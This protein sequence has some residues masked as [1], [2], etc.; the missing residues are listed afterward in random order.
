MTA[1]TAQPLMPAPHFVHRWLPPETHRGLLR[2]GLIVGAVALGIAVMNW[3][4]KPSFGSLVQALVYSYAISM[5]I[6]FISDPLRIA[7]RRFLQLGAPNYWTLNLRSGAWMLLGALF[8]YALGTWIGDAYA[9]VSTFALLS[10]S[11]KRFWGFLISS[12]AISLGFLFF[13]YQRERA[14]SLQKQAAEARLRLLETQLEPHMLFNTLANLRAL[15]VIDQDK[16]VDMLDRLNGYLRA[17]LRA[18]R[19]ADAEQRPHTLQ[20]EFDRL[21]DYLELMAVRM[22]PRLRYTLT[23]PPA[24]ARHPLPP[25]LLQPLVENA[26]RHG[27][28]PHL[29]GGEIVV[30]AQA[31]GSSLLLRVNDTGAGCAGA[32]LADRPGG[33]FGLSQ[34]RERLETAFGPAPK[35]IERLQW[36]SAPNQG[37]Q[38]LLRLPLDTAA[39]ESTAP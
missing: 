20:D 8:G 3:L 2:R 14:L 38:I 11:P 7:A 27:L 28:E 34:V 25:L 15:I 33:G 26:I 32:P 4:N 18:S 31:E 17:T 30:S 1:H 23:L 24:L 13:F 21:G 12:L 22:G 39:L 37:T 19:S 10:E 35:G 6:W 5:S 36:Q 29:A 9:G 16:A